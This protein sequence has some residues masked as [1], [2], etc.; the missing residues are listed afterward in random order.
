VKEDKFVLLIGKAIKTKFSASIMQALQCPLSV[1]L[2][3]KISQFIGRKLLEKF[4]SI[5]LDVSYLVDAYS[6]EVIT[7]META[8]PSKILEPIHH[9]TWCHI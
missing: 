6:V 3:N 5:V 2:W 1:K 8:G 4:I 7:Q 9:T